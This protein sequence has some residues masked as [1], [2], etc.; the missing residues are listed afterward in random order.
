[1]QKIINYSNDSMWKDAIVAFA[2][3]NEF[4]AIY[5]DE[6][7]KRIDGKRVSY[8]LIFRNL[9]VTAEHEDDEAWACVNCGD[10][11]WWSAKELKEVGIFVN[12]KNPL[13][14]PEVFFEKALILH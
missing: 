9:S 10:S 1:M 11:E 7:F 3:G 5:K 8:N 13:P 6:P 14:K 2:K 4:I 12:N